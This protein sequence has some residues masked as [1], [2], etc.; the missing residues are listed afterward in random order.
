MN[1]GITA[2]LHKLEVKGG[3]D[4]LRHLSN[5]DL[6]DKMRRT[7]D[8]L[9]GPDAAFP[10]LAEWTSEEEAITTI[11]WYHAGP[12]ELHWFGSLPPSGWRPGVRPR[13]PLR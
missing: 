5:A 12:E 7:I 2:R 11:R 6:Q 13:D 9:G 4:D 8:A 3:H 10:L 1:R